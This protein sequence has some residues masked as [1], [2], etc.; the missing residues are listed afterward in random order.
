MLPNI[1][2]TLII[3]AF[4]GLLGYSINQKLKINELNTTLN[5]RTAELLAGATRLYISDTNLKECNRSLQ[6][7]N[8]HIKTIQTDNETLKQNALK[9]KSLIDTKYKNIPPPNQTLKS[10]VDFYESILKRLSDENFKN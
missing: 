9:F 4:L 8:D 5:E 3:T 6:K 7:Q 2:Q 10:K 1:R